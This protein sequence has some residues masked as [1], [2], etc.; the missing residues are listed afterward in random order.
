[1][2]GAMTVR[3]AILRAAPVFAAQRNRGPDALRD[4]ISKAGVPV[5]LAAEVVEFLPIAVARAM[6][7]GMGVRFADHYV[8]RTAQ[9]RVIGEKRLEDEPVFREG[10]ALAEEIGRLGEEVLT[11]V[12]NWSPEYQAISKALSGGARAEELTCA[13][14]TMLANNDDRRSFDDTSGGPA[15]RKRWWK[16]WG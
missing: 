6:L 13:P 12:V 9:G 4:E 16:F 1:M 8:R 5:A 10:L 7:H 14:P 15:P 3:E 2:G 11:A